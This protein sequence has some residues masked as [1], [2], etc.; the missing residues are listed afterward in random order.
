[1]AL[2]VPLTFA[3]ACSSGA[4]SV[5]PSISESTVASGDV[6]LH[7][8]TL[9]PPAA[10]DTIITV[11]GGPGLSL[12]AM[13]PYDALAGNTRRVIGYD[14]R[15]SGRSTAP[16]DGDF[17]LA[18]QVADLEQVRAASGAATV[19]LIGESWGG[20]LAEAYAAT[21]PGHVRALVLVGAVPL[22]RA[23]FLAGQARFRAHITE[24][25]AAGLIPTPLPAVAGN[26]C[27]AQLLAEL[28]AYLADP[29]SVAH[30]DP[31][32]CTSSTSQA[33][34]RALLADESVPSLA[35]ELSNFHGPALVVMGDHDA[36]GLE[37]LDRNVALLRGA[38]VT[39]V[40]ATGAG[41]LVAIEQTQ[42][43]LT[44]ISALLAG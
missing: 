34:Y 4:P 37:W 29:H 40:V 20:A 10:A 19:T 41:H 21:H 44:R 7:V 32:T 15:G 8:R 42:Q 22:D 28:P 3:A 12:Q 13:A 25:Q 2:F 11:H 9:G 36:F 43:L 14:Q 17:G 38:R 30:I 18:A 39:R 26:S 23:A 31:G 16:K 24:L 33:T 27:K 5:H 6:T 35:E 1:V